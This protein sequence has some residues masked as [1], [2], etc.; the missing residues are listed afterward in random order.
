MAN[1]ISSKK[2]VIRPLESKDIKSV[3]DLLQAISDF[4]PCKTDYDQLWKSYHAQKNVIAIVAETNIGIGGFAS[5]LIEQKL[6][7]GRVGHIEDVV[8]HSELRELG[9]GSMLIEALIEKAKLN[10]CFKVVLWCESNN[11]AFYEKNSFKAVGSAME[12]RLEMKRRETLQPK[13]D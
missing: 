4:R 5:L 3:I 11:A 10:G 6:R 7:G 9:I 13:R 1:K 12:Y 8:T 2:T